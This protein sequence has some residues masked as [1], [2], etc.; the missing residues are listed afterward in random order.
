MA[1]IRADVIGSPGD[2]NGSL[3]MMTQLSASPTTS[4]PCQKLEVAKRTEF[5]VALNSR[6]SAERGARALH[7][8]GIFE[9]HRRQLVDLSQVRVA[10]EQHERAAAAAFENLDDLASGGLHERGRARLR[11][12]ARQ[13]QDGLTFVVE[14]GGQ[15]DLGRTPDAQPAS[16]IVERAVNGQRRRREHG[17]VHAVEQ[18]LANDVRDIDGRGPQVHAPAADIQVV[19]VARI[20]RARHELDVLPQVGGAA[21]ER[22]DVFRNVLGQRNHGLERFQA[23]DECGALWRGAVEQT[24]PDPD[25][26]VRACR[27]GLEAQHLQRGEERARMIAHALGCGPQVVRSIRVGHQP[28]AER[29]VGVSREVVDP[30]VAD[31][32][33]E[34]LRRDVLE[35]MRLVQNR[36]PARRNDFAE[37]ALTHGGIGAEQVMI[38]DDDVGLRGALPHERH[39]T[40]VEAGALPPDAVLGG[41]G[42]VGPERQILG[43]VLHFRAVTGLGRPRPFVD[44]FE[45]E[46]LV[47]GAYGAARR[48]ARRTGAGRD[49]CRVL[50][51]R[52][53]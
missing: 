52:S 24:A 26:G 12:L 2:A 48:A 35:L 6:M 29:P 10:R 9:L 36:V 27:R 30:V 23:R 8:H 33:P 5:G 44:R 37:R 7:E 21:R 22:K 41:C 40:V 34:V 43:Q 51:C 32:N 18:K 45:R 49:N 53:R 31:R 25:P 4:T 3:S 50:S 42:D 38:D 16:D 15:P 20:V 39:E 13:V 47:G 17:R 11:H 1:S 46:P 28:R 14:L 19:H